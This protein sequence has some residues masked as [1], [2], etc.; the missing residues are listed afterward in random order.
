MR[1]LTHRHPSKRSTVVA[2]RLL[3]LPHTTAR[4]GPLAAHTPGAASRRIPAAAH[5]LHA[6]QRTSGGWGLTAAVAA[7]CRCPQTGRHERRWRR[8]RRRRRRGVAG[9]LLGRR[10]AP[11]VAAD[12]PA[13]HT[14]RDGLLAARCSRPGSRWRTADP[15]TAGPRAARDLHRL[16]EE[17][18]GK[19]RRSAGR[20]LAGGRG[21][22]LSR[23][24]AGGCAAGS[25][26]HL[27]DLGCC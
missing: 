5:R 22:P 17:R 26:E 19:E 20:P 14:A 10:P 4:A 13:P 21:P 18:K 9:P 1:G 8:R 27:R 23:E 3:Q 7:S 11:S 6:R 24:V 15:A 25:D 2:R 16:R 12:V